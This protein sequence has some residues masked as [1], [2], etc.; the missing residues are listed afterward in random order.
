MRSGM[1]GKTNR[2]LMVGGTTRTYVAYLPESASPTT[3][4]PFVYVFHG[5]SQTGQY[6]F[7]ATEYSKLADSEGIA[8]VF[9]DGQGASSTTSTGSLAPW[10][11]TDGPAVCGAG[12]LVSALGDTDL[13]FVDAIRA[14]IKQDQCLDE[15]HV[16]ST[17]FSMGGYMTHHIACMRP[18]FRAAA[19]HS[20]GTMADLSSCATDHMPIIIFHG[21]GDGLILDNC[22][23]PEASPD[24]SFTTH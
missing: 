11:V 9:P 12:A 15:D 20:G 13:D 21:T 6:L 17:G 10:K 3:P 14:D 16:F 5:A 24:P 19:P 23:D 22:D 7:D 1:R 8:V 2:S 4:L 18:D